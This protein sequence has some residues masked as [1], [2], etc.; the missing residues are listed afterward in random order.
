[1]LIIPAMLA[2]KASRQMIPSWQFVQTKV[3]KFPINSNLSQK[4]NEYANEYSSAGIF[5]LHC[6][7][8]L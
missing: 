8:H 1:M 7:S 2:R 3:K 4:V 5:R 6:P